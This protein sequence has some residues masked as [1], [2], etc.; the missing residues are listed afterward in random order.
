MISF[1]ES[2]QAKQ[3]VIYNTVEALTPLDQW[4]I[5]SIL[6]HIHG[7]TLR[8]TCGCSQERLSFLLTFFLPLWWHC[9]LQS[10]LA[11]L[12][13]LPLIL[14]GKS[15]IDWGVGNWGL[16]HVPLWNIPHALLTDPLV[17]VS[18]LWP[19]EH[20]NIITRSRNCPAAWDVPSSRFL[21]RYSSN[22]SPVAWFTCREKS[23]A[24]V[25]IRAAFSFWLHW[26]LPRESP[27]VLYSVNFESISTCFGS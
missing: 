11:F 27:R 22:V 20:P 2:Q 3:S 23:V 7:S 15:V 1:L 21:G 10:P 16:E 12:P 17:K 18:S 14:L 9:H 13:S 24:P 19:T 26:S 25:C 8:H 4:V 5:F 6:S